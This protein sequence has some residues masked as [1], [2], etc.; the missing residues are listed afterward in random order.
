MPNCDFYAIEDDALNVIDF[1]FSNTPCQVFELYSEP[2][3]AIRQFASS[4]DIAD[5]YESTQNTVLRLSLYAPTMLGSFSFHRLELERP[6]HR[7]GTHRFRAHGW[8]AIQLYFSKVTDKGLAPSHT[9]HNSERRASAWAEKV[10]DLG[11]PESWDWREVVRISRQINRYIAINGASKIGSRPIL[12]HAF[13]W[14]QRGGV[15]RTA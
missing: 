5:A 13:E 10:A 3:E 1:I 7:A 11:S 15:L 9:N 6:H 4:G 12:K 2:G 8:G 14:S